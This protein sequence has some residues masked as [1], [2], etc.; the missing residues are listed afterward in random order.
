MILEDLLKVKGSAIHSIDPQ[1]SL[2]EAVQTL[3]RHNIGSLVVCRKGESCNEPGLLGI[4]TERDILRACAAT[5][6]PLDFVRVEERMTRC[7][8]VV[9]PAD[10]ISDAMCVMTERRFRHLPVVEQGKLVGIISIGDTVK[11]K[12]DELCRENHYLKSYIQS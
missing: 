9:S 11:A 12:H 8:I 2:D 7:P 1:A 5:R 6:G 3:V 10:D 4:I